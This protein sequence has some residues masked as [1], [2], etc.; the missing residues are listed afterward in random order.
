MKLATIE[1]ILDIQPIDGADKIELA[2]VQGWQV[3]IKKGEYQVGDLCVYIPIDTIVNT[4]KQ[5]FNFLANPKNLNEWVKINT[6]CIKGKYSQGLVIPISNLDQTQTYQEDD[7]VSVQLDVKKYEKESRNQSVPKIST[8]TF[9][10]DIIPI[11]DEDNLRTKYKVL[12]ELK[13]KELYITK[14]MDGSSMTIIKQNDDFMVCSRKQIL[15]ST[16]QMYQWIHQEKIDDRIKSYGQ[17]LAI[18]GEFCGPK[19]NGNQMGLTEYNFFVFNIKN[20]DSGNFYGWDDIK[21]ICQEIQLE[22]VPLID[23]F[24]CDDTWT[25]NKFQELSNQQTYTLGTGKQVPAE[26]IVIRPINPATSNVLNKMLSV[27]VINQKYKD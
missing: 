4:T 21:R 18:Q 11:T 25:I 16:A 12:N 22:T 1:R 6:K 2:T 14:K 26:G 23:I 17:N 3:V 20:L 8:I 15:D 13:D 27:K 7:D 5:C 19:V 24:V 10:K 9:P